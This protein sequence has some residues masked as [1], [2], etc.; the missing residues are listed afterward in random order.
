MLALKGKKTL[1]DNLNEKNK[2]PRMI[3]NR[4][5]GGIR[6]AFVGY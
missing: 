3:T 2:N 1:T 5:G 4:R 6:K